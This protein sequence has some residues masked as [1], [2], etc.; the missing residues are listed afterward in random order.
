MS[1]FYPDLGCF[2]KEPSKTKVVCGN[3]NWKGTQDQ[4]DIIRDAQERLAPGYEVPA[5]ECPK[6][7]ALAYL[8]RAERRRMPGLQPQAPKVVKS[9]LHAAEWAVADMKGVDDA[10]ESNRLAEA[11]NWMDNTS[12]SKAIGVVRRYYKL[13]RR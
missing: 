9:L 6:C 10:W 12:L 7:G 5:G 2:P 4:T 3:C 11:V 1:S 8:T 13:G